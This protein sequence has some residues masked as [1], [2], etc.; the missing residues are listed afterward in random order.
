ML[1]FKKINVFSN[2][3]SRTR[4]C[5]F[6]GCDSAIRH[7]HPSQSD[8]PGRRAP[9]DTKHGQHDVTDYI[10]CFYIWQLVLLNPFTLSAHPP[11][12]PRNPGAALCLGGQRTLAAP[13]LCARLGRVAPRPA[14]PWGCMLATAA[15]GPR[16]GNWD[17]AAGTPQ[18]QG[19]GAP[20]SPRSLL[21]LTDWPNHSGRALPR[22]PL[23]EP[24][25][26]WPTAGSEAELRGVCSFLQEAEP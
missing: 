1:L 5:C 15:W 22:G 25:V 23:P 2:Y 10:P 17:L 11:T 26:L 14:G 8:P 24:T 9:P 16:A 19:G 12:W 4:L 20:E 3:S 13:F 21:R 7:L 18:A 6:Q